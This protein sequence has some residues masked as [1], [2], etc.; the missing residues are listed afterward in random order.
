MAYSFKERTL[1]EYPSGGYTLWTGQK[2]AHNASTEHYES[3]TG[4]T[5]PGPPYTKLNNWSH[6]SSNV[7]GCRLTGRYNY[8][9][10]Y[11]TDYTNH[12]IGAPSRYIHLTNWSAL[13][14]SA[15]AAVN[16]DK[17]IVDL[18]LF[19]FELRELPSL[20]RSL[21]ISLAGGR[22][23]SRNVGDAHLSYQFGW[24]PLFNDLS[25]LLNLAQETE[26]RIDRLKRANKRKRISG[27]LPGYSHSWTT[28]RTYFRNHISYVYDYS[29]SQKNWFVGTYDVPDLPT[30]DSSGIGRLSR[31]LGLSGSAST[32]W[33]AIPWT[34][35]I[36]YF[37]NIGDYMAAMRGNTRW[38]MTNLC[39]MSHTVVK[40]TARRSSYYP[41]RWESTNAHIY[42]GGTWVTKERQVSPIVVPR[43]TFTP[44]LSG[45]QLANLGALAVSSKQHYARNG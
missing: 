12:L 21:G 17:P 30:L 9:S 28:G 44:F 3:S 29:V 32:I 34:W 13:N 5:S 7:Q 39:V 11:W 16:P 15:L 6:L 22:G 42:G 36:D 14:T 8:A 37:T 18:P 24:A 43:F 41:S 38:S 31:A 2:V 33:N 4:S 40:A 25:S 23:A 26:K 35:L 19:L 1:S 27:N 20:I 10:K 45:Q